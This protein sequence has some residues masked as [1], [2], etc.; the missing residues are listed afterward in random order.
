MRWAIIQ[1]TKVINIIEADQSFIDEHHA[2]A[3]LIDDTYCGIGFDYINGEFMAPPIQIDI[4]D[5]SVS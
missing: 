3:V 2:D 1:A 5:E 4:S